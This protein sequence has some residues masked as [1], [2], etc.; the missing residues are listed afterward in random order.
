[1]Y[2]AV[3]DDNIADR[4][5]T[6]RLLSRQSDRIFKEHGARIYIDS[7]GNEDA[8]M[9]NPQMYAGLF[10]DMVSG[11]VNGYDIV[12]ILINDLRI[13]K[14][15]IMCCSTLDYRKMIADAHLKADNIYFLD[16]PIKVDEL[17]EMVDMIFREDSKTVP[18]LELR[19]KQETYYAHG[20]DIIYIR[21]NHSELE[22]KLTEGRTFAVIAD[23]FNIYDQCRIFPQICPVSDNAL[24]NVNHVQRTSFGKATMDNGDTIPVGFAY[25]TYI[26]KTKDNLAGSQAQ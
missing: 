2:L 8:F 19:G 13:E 6:E 3:C 10:I 22:V 11:D 15:I 24:V 21:K 25:R 9:A 5:Q 17:T 23:L 12:H 4:K 20:D 18:T 26:K 14:P 7:Y 1:M 16:K